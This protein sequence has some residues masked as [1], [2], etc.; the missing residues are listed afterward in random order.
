SLIKQAD[1]MI[2][3]F[4]PGVMDRLGLG[5]DVARALNPRLIYAE[6]TGYGKIGPWRNKP[7]QDLLVQAISGLPW[8]NGNDGQPPLPFGLSVVDM[9]AGA[10]LV[11]GILACLVRRGITGKGGRVEVSLLESVIDFQFEV[12]TTF[13]N[14]G[15]QL[16]HRSAVH[17]ANA[18]LP[19]PYGIYPTADGHIALA[20][21][22]IVTLGQLLNC[23]AL[24]NYPDPGTWFSQ[25]DEIRR[26]LAGHLLTQT[27]AHWLGK[28]EA[29]GYWCADVLNWRQLVQH[30]G[31]KA[32]NM[33]QTVTR[34][35][36]VSLKT[37]RCPIRIDGQILTSPVGAP[38][39]GR[40]TEQVLSAFHL[41]TET[42]NDP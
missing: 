15:G 26:I 24:L 19:A 10:H 30:D 39:I 4:R 32:L 16:P 27:T 21:G 41:S 42:N 9:F 17:N 1:V 8:L 18:Y 11:Q 13:L 38:R 33:L 31:F 23:P 37:T 3:N 34:D 5:C 12:F 20:M 22:S 35:E 36:N 6:V 25:R 2:Q 28:L 29:A 14:D 7:G 40:H